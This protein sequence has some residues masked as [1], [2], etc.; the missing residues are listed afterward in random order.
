MFYTRVFCTK[1]WRQKLQIFVL[2]L[3]LFGTKILY[4]K[5]GRKMLMK[6]TP[7]SPRWLLSAGRFSEAE[8]IMRKIGKWNRTDRQP[9]FESEFQ[10]RWAKV[11]KAFAVKIIYNEDGSARKITFWNTVK[12][13][14]HQVTTR[15][16]FV[17]L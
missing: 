9:E 10:E 4:K 11:V 1:F 15:N 5:H 7:E 2:D 16:Y 3:R 13:I 17:R 12:E 6:L 14:I 8:A